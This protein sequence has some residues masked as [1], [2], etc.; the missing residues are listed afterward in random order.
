MQTTTWT[1]GYLG[2]Y[3]RSSVS[4]VSS[5]SAEV[6]EFLAMRKSASPHSAS[7]GAAAFS[8]ARA[9]LSPTPRA[10]AAARGN[11]GG[12]ASSYAIAPSVIGTAGASFDLPGQVRRCPTWLM[13]R[14]RREAALGRRAG[15]LGCLARRAV[16]RLREPALTCDQLV[17]YSVWHGRGVQG[18]RRPDSQEPAR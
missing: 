12:F 6:P 8:A 16:G 5:W 9:S 11:A 15:A 4:G 2:R 1:T 14:S 13:G 10:V 18:P 3:R 17:T 7:P